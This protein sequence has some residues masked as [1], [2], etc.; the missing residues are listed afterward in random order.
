VNIDSLKPVV[1]LFVG[2]HD[3]KNFSNPSLDNTTR[4]IDEISIDSDDDWILID[5]KAKSFLWHQIRRMIN[6]WLKVINGELKKD[7]LIKALHTPATVV[8]Y[9]LAPAAPLFLMDVHYNDVEF[10]V[11]G[12]ILKKMSN[13]LLTDWHRNT[14]KR[15][16]LN[17]FIESVNQS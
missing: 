13:R 16:F 10:E 12:Q 14:L 8:D 6:S 17:Y 2:S 4:T 5:I 3:F 7:K 1:D 15:K 11:N 9:G